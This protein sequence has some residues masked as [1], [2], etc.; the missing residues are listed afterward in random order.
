MLMI[1]SDEVDADHPDSLRRWQSAGTESRD[2][3]PTLLQRL[4]M[5]EH[6]LGDSH[7]ECRATGAQF[8]PTRSSVS[9][10][11]D[12]SG[13]QETAARRRRHGNVTVIGVIYGLS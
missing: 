1:A 2:A 10:S 6:Q 12:G 4:L 9:M 8:N 5:A 3:G 13:Q 7:H 11:A